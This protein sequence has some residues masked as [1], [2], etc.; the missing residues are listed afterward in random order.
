MASSSARERVKAAFLFQK[1][2]GK[3]GIKVEQT[4]VLRR[5]GHLAGIYQ[6]TPEKFAKELEKR[7]GIPEIYEQ[8]LSGKVLDFLAQN[9]KIEEVVPPSAPV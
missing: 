1:I 9:A 2:A 8:I 7:N 6:M 3:E 4:E 5:I